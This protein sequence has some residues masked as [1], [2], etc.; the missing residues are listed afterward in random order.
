[1]VMLP[2]WFEYVVFGVACVVIGV[3][4]LPFLAFLGFLAEW[5]WQ[6]FFNYLGRNEI[7]TPD[8]DEM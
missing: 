3:I 8:D 2:P 7:Q 4:G 6:K 1:M 5:S